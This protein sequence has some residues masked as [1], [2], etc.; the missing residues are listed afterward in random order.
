MNNWVLMY[1]QRWEVTKHVYAIAVQFLCTVFKYCICTY[2]CLSQ[3]SS[4]LFHY[5]PK[6]RSNYLL[7]NLNTLG[8]YLGY[9]L[10]GDIL[11]QGTSDSWLVLLPNLQSDECDNKKSWPSNPLRYLCTL[12]QSFPQKWGAGEDWSSYMYR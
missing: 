11:N 12:I 7:Y 9:K 3:K 5:I 8:Y 2:I 10:L 6:E 4:D 1:I